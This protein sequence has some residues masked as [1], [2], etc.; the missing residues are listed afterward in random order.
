VELL[1]VSVIASM[2][3]FMLVALAPSAEPGRQ[4]H[5]AMVGADPQARRHHRVAYSAQVVQRPAPRP[6]R[7]RGERV[8]AVA[9]APAVAEVTQ[10]ISPAAE[11][12]SPLQL[13]KPTAVPARLDWARQTSETSRRYQGERHADN[14]VASLLRSSPTS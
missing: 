5:R 14:L 11:G 2:I 13:P 10:P 4:P 12:W 6:L 1:A 3:L 8:R 7:V 9:A